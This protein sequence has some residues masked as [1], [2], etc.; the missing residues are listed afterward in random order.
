M[1]ADGTFIQNRYQIVRKIGQ[2]GMGA[3]YEAIDTR[4]GNRVALK[5]TIVEGEQFDR[6]FEREAR[7]LASLRHAALPVVSDFFSE[8]EGQFLIMQYIPGD[9]LATLLKQ[10]SHPFPVDQV[11]DW[12]DQILSV[13]E[14]LHRQEPPIIHRDIKPQNLKLTSE[15]QVVLLDFGLAK[16]MQQSQ[17]TTTTRSLFGYTPQYAPMEQIQGTG[18][19]SRSDLYAVGATIYNLLS[20]QAPADALTRGSRMLS[21]EAD[22]LKPVHEINAEVPVALSQVLLQ[23]MSM[24]PRERFQTATAMRMALQQ[25]NAPAM[26]GETV[27]MT[28]LP[29]V[30][31]TGPTQR[32]LTSPRPAESVT[33]R[34]ERPATPVIPPEPAVGHSQTANPRR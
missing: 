2:G 32:V 3:V 14:Y 12:A 13:L 5:Q 23:A 4:L 24:N 10:R 22:S 21:G 1:L 20:G 34:P 30:P 25:P 33:Q 8:G 7:L 29:P 9:D 18:T 11:L 27:H 17:T 6:A 26:T 16:G 19:D 31:A 15:G 28:P